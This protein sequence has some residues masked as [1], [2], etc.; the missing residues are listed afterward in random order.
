MI[1][2][3]LTKEFLLNRLE[4]SKLEKQG[5]LPEIKNKIFYLLGKIGGRKNMLF[6]NI[7]KSTQYIFL[8]VFG[9]R[10]EVC[11]TPIGMFRIEKIGKL[12]QSKIS[13]K[14]FRKKIGGQNHILFGN[15]SKSTLYFCLVFSG[16]H[17]EVLK[18]CILES[19]II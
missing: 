7:S 6:E 5:N 15:I 18:N 4:C 19:N 11:N 16:P 1:V 2:S 17:K 12:F 8:I 9:Q 13:N 3:G 10:K 14:F